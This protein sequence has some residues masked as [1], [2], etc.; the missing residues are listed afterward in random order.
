[1]ITTSTLWL[2]MSLGILVAGLILGALLALT[3]F[4]RRRDRAAEREFHV[5]QH[6]AL[7]PAP[8]EVIRTS[9]FEFPMDPP[10]AQIEERT[11]EV[12]APVVDTPVEHHGADEDWSPTQELEMVPARPLDPIEAMEAEI[13]EEVRREIARIF[14]PI[15]AALARIGH[16]EQ[17]TCEISF[18]HLQLAIAAERSGAL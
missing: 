14:D 5:P 6:R 7:D 3:E 13:E 18:A 17:D 9:M 2:D 10:R 8:V 15:E 4:D 16:A 12:P 11:E 1:M